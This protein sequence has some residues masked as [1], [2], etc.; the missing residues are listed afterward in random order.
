M[1]CSQA[2]QAPAGF[3]LARRGL[4]GGVL[5]CGVVVIWG[6]DVRGLGFMN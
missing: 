4:Q 5:L 3:E 6:W 2:P 1:G